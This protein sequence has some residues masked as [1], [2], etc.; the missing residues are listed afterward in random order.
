MS[1]DGIVVGLD[2]PDGKG[3]GR[4]G[5]LD[6]GFS[7]IGGH[8]FV[9][10]DKSQAG[11]AINGSELVKS[12]AFDEIRDEFYIDLHEVPWAGDGEDS[13]V[14]FGSGFSFSSQAVVLNDFAD[15]EGGGDL[16]VAMV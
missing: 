4:E 14:A 10:L 9:E 16:G 6:K 15:G 2:D 5:I 11:A 7:G 8:F 12:S 13:A 3:K 1:K